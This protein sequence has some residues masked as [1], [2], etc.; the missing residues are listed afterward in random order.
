MAE[1]FVSYRRSDSAGAAGRLVYS[2]VRENGRGIAFRDVVSL[3]PGDR[4][5]Q[6][7]VQAMAR[8]EVVLVLIGEHWLA[9][10]QRRLA[11]PETDY[12]RAEVAA[13]LQQGKRVVPVLLGAAPMPTSAQLP[14]DME[15][16]AMCHA[17]TVRD[18]AW[19]SDVARLADSIGRPYRFD[20]M[21]WRAALV[22]PSL[23]LASWQLAPLLFDRSASDYT[24]I[25][26]WLLG[27]SLSYLAAEVAW[28]QRH[29]RR[30]AA[31]RQR[32][33]PGSVTAAVL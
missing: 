21:L 13:A 1:L 3:L 15:P 8:A 10:L 33:K 9:E 28:A 18:E 5:D 22:L 12:V 4:F 2:L 26:Q 20:R 14:E 19:E 32:H 17:I 30:L 29:R 23:L 24:F 11:L 6:A 31:L 16:L 25:R 7:L 27:V